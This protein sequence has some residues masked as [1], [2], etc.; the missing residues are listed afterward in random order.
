MDEEGT[1]KTTCPF[2]GSP[3]KRAKLTRTFNSLASFGDVGD[4]MISECDLCRLRLIFRNNEWQ[5]TDSSRE[6]YQGPPLPADIPE[7][8]KKFERFIESHEPK[9]Q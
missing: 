3:L 1:V 9:Q 7:R 2:C 8:V 4:Y 6:D 5:N